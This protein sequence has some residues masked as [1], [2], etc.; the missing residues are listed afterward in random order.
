MSSHHVVRDNQEPAIILHDV[1]YEDY[2]LVMNLLEWSPFVVLFDTSFE[3][4]NAWGV[5]VDLLVSENNPGL[6]HEYEKTIEDQKPFI[7]KHCSFAEL[8]SFL[9]E[10]GHSMIN[11]LGE[12]NKVKPFFNEFEIVTFDKASQYSYF[13]TIFEKW[14]PKGECL[15]IDCDHDYQVHNLSFENSKYT[16]EK[17]GLV[18]VN[19]KSTF[20]IKENW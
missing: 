17:D 16:V 11:Y 3:I 13:N 15:E 2:P 6:L 14:Y 1:R 8:M 7:V 4:V 19:S 20:W 5:K 10:K 9:K 12:L 18:T